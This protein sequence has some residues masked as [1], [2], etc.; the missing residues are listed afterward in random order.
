MSLLRRLVPLVLA[1]SLLMPALAQGQESWTVAVYSTMNPLPIG[2]CAAVRLDIK[3]PNTRDIPRTPSG[4]RVTIADFDVTVTSADGKSAAPYWI[5]AYHLN[6]CGCQGGS[7]GTSAVITATY[8]ARALVQEARVRDVSIRATG[9]FSVAKPQNTIDP[10]ACT[11]SSVAPTLATTALP[12]TPISTVTKTA[13]TTVTIAPA[14][15][16]IPSTPTISTAP[17][18]TRPSSPII[19]TASLPEIPPELLAAWARMG[20]PTSAD[21]IY[22]KTMEELQRALTAWIAASGGTPLVPLADQPIGT[23]GSTGVRPTGFRLASSLPIIA[24]LVWDA[25]PN[26]VTYSV[27]RAVGTAV[28]VNR[29]TVGPDAEKALN[30][31]I[32]DPRDTYIYTLV[33]TYADGTW[34]TSPGVEFISPPLKNPPGFTA[35]DRGLGNVEFQWQ[36]VGGAVRYRL[37]GP[38]M[39][40]TGFFATGTTTS[41]PKTPA[42]A[43]SWK[44]T[45]LYQGNFADYA[46][47]ATASAVVRVLPPHTLPWLSKNN[48]VGSVE[49]VQAPRMMVTFFGSFVE[50]VDCMKSGGI[51]GDLTDYDPKKVSWLGFAAPLCGREIETRKFNGLKQW[52]NF[53]DQRL[54]ADSLQFVEETKYGNAVDLGVGRRTFC[55]QSPHPRS[56]GTLTTMCY[57]TAHGVVPGQAGFN[58]FNTITSPSEGAGDD[59]ILS[60]VISKDYTGTTFLVFLKDSLRPYGRVAATV[61]LDTE[62]PKYVPHACISCH[63]GT[64]NLKTRK[65]DGASFLPLDPGQLVFASADHQASQEEGMRNINAMIA[66]SEPTSAVAA[67][68]RG[69]YGN[70]ISVPGTVAKVDYVP[71][72]WSTQPGIYRSLVKPYCATCHLAAPAFRNFASWENFKGNAEPIKAAVCKA[73]TMPHAELQF[74]AFWTKDT[75]PVYLPGLLASTLDWEPNIKGAPPSCP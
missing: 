9:D 37:D 21:S 22:G 2:Q 44:L 49:T 27:K 66:D 75:G 13:P 46:N 58:D 29:V 57:A 33:V 42:G 8:P 56:P 25:M 62:G 14:P 53:P 41:F 1:A 11:S 63:G 70:Q 50:A 45:A 24:S 32:P 26:A 54:W 6:V 59:F 7:A 18:A 68:I 3:D 38:G 74:R 47:P 48:G 23:R 28:P 51:G 34:G 15:A 30:D 52:L 43:N 20:I 5:D 60:M 55:T 16:P 67:Y 12:A 10:L 64:Y 17:V 40:G 69:L 31:V 39:P 36:A 35:K 72:G 65:V 4:T 19:A 61:S 73:H 71:Q